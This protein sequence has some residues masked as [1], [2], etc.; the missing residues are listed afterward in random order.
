[1]ACEVM[2]AL[3]CLLAYLCE[4]RGSHFRTT[5]CSSSATDEKDV[6]EKAPPCQ[7]M[8]GQ[9]HHAGEAEPPLPPPGAACA[10]HDCRLCG[11]S[12]SRRCCG[13]EPVLPHPRPSASRSWRACAS[14]ADAEHIAFA[15]TN[16]VRFLL[17]WN[18]KH[19]ANRTILRRVAQR[20]ESH[21]RYRKSRR[22]VGIDVPVR[23][24][25]RLGL[26]IGN[27][28]SLACRRETAPGARW[29]QYDVHR[30][31]GTSRCL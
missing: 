30:E 14:R 26:K 15:A 23:I 10:Q 3:T 12:P 5:R 9:V 13:R 19:L 17:T 24:A 11:R 8:A 20:C 28:K 29:H 4:P 16:S 7:R 22:R 6:R 2:P 27:G 1:M 21:G 18:Y 31:L 25:D